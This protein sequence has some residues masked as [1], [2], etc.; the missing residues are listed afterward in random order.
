MSEP[1]RQAGKLSAEIS[2]EP[3]SKQES[4]ESNRFPAGGLGGLAVP[5]LVFASGTAAPRVGAPEAPEERNAEAVAA[6]TLEA[7]RRQRELIT[8]DHASAEASN[9][10]GAVVRRA[11]GGRPLLPRTRASFEAA[12]GTDLSSVRVH[13]GPQATELNAH[14]GAR[15]FTIGADIYFAREPDIDTETGRHLL[16][17][18]LAHAIQADRSPVLRRMVV[19]QL[20]IGHDK[21][22]LP[23]AGKGPEPRIVRVSI[24]GRPPPTFSSSMGDHSTAFTVHVNSI[25]LA[26]EG[27][28]LNEAASR[29]VELIN[30]IGL[31][32]GSQMAADLPARQASMW[33]EAAKRVTTAQNALLF[34]TPGVNL[35]SALQ[36]S[37]AA[38]LEVRELVPLSTINTGS[39][40]KATSGKGKGEE[41]AA[42]RAQSAGVDQPPDLLRSQ[43]VGLLDVRAVALACIELD[44]VRLQALAPGLRADMSTDERA[45]HYVLQHLRSIQTG[46]PGALAAAAG[47]SPGARS[48]DEK[49]DR[50]AARDLDEQAIRSIMPD[51]MQR[52]VMPLAQACLFE[53]L[54]IQLAAVEAVRKDIR[55]VGPVDTVAKNRKRDRDEDDDGKNAKSARENL[56]RLQQDEQFQLIRLNTIEKS[57]G[58]KLTPAMP[59]VVPSAPVDSGRPT[60]NRT[61]RSLFTVE[62]A[63]ASQKAQQRENKI[64]A[65]MLKLAAPTVK[66]QTAAEIEEEN[67]RKGALAIQVITDN[68]GLIT[69]LRSAGRPPSPFA[70][71]M[72]AHTTAW[73]VHVDRVRQLIIGRS[74]AAARKSVQDD[75]SEE[76]KKMAERLG[77]AFSF[78]SGHRE[79]KRTDVATDDDELASLQNA[80]VRHLEEV[81]LS[82]GTGLPAADT[83]GKYE[84]G[85]R[86]VLLEHLG[87]QQYAGSQRNHRP[88]EVLAAIVGL[89]D[90]S[91]LDEDSGKFTALDEL[92]I[93]RG[94][95]PL[96]RAVLQH[97]IAIEASY[98]GALKAAGLPAIPADLKD[99]DPIREA[100]QLSSPAVKTVSEQVGQE[101]TQ[102]ATKRRKKNDSTADKSAVSTSTPFAFTW[103]EAVLG[104]RPSSAYSEGSAQPTHSLLGPLGINFQAVLPAQ[105]QSSAE[106]LD[107]HGNLQPDRMQRFV[108]AYRADVLTPGTYLSQVEGPA[109]ARGF[110]LTLSVYR[111]TPPP[112]FSRIEN[113]GGGDC[114]IHAISDVRLA[115][116][117]RTAGT[118]SSD[119]PARLGP[120]GPR[121]VA[122]DEV[123]RIRAAV[124][125]QLQDADLRH[126]ALDIVHNEIEGIGTAGLGISVQ[127]LLFDR[128]FQFA[129]ATAR[130]QSAR[131]KATSE[132][133]RKKEEQKKQAQLRKQTKALAKTG[134][135]A[136]AVEPD[137]TVSDTA[138]EMM[139]VIDPGAGLPILP[140][141]QYPANGHAETDFAL[142]HTG[143]NHYVA[144]VRTG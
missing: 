36:E 132:I 110:G 135:P 133:D 81:N 53:E 32:P 143:G 96:E 136:M 124:A 63:E 65:E 52:T 27:R 104:K 82:P 125:P 69:E 72:G 8:P 6:R 46:F 44:P 21:D 4:N 80:I 78:P 25:Q 3:S 88:E 37:I 57:L 74:L 112:G 90:V 101:K 12:M 119:I 105:Q 33:K 23:E 106:W 118:A 111:D 59:T 87:L 123:T 18:E 56:K 30:R 131:A 76:R 29:M 11:I 26:L 117:A 71:T 138:P 38:Y 85:H 114:L 91:S 121:A 40:S 83:G 102:R 113:I 100:Q 31:L 67:E 92:T 24:V 62:G 93:K 130:Y 144:I 77:A 129:I 122:A 97:L 43:V 41:A 61:P 115:M 108:D 70:G 13:S 19:A 34:P 98:P 84:A 9:A 45:F 126:A 1:V 47:A 134:G 49:K 64:T 39:I 5:G 7:L 10:H 137:T 17:H 60:R 42:L 66:Q 95:Q 89:L 94:K 68:K 99:K 16:A 75:L 73:A 20:E 50:D 22:V 15:A 51:L 128:G 116:Q 120:S 140:Q 35:V 48:G 142:L 28:P 2:C 127:R 107:P 139:A 103:D 55:N 14:L 141:E 58:R 79:P 109:V 54:A 86:Q